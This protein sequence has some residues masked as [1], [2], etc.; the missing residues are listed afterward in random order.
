MRYFIPFLIVLFALAVLLRVDFFF[1]VAYFLFG[2]WVLARLWTRSAVDHLRAGRRFGDHAFTGDTV[3]VE[4]TLRNTGWLPLPWL[5]VGEGLPVQLQTTPFQRRV[6][7]LAP[8][9]EQRFRYDLTCRQRG[10]YAVGPL[11]ARTGDVLGVTQRDLMLVETQHLTVYPRIVPLRRLALPTRS[12][13]AV[14]PARAPLFEDPARLMGVREYQRGDSPR[15][16]HWPATARTSRLVVKQYQP[17]IARETLIC[18]DLF[19]DDYSRQRRYDATEL[20]IVAAASLAN[21]I[22]VAEG[23]PVGLATVALDPLTGSRARFALPPRRER[24]HLIHLLE[25]LARVQFTPGDAD[26][27]D[28]AE[29][30]FVNLVRRQS[31][32]LAWGAT[33]VLITGRAAPDLAHILLHLQRSGFAVTLLLMQPDR[34]PDGAALTGVPGVP[35]REVWSERDL[36]AV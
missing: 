4:L 19:Q 35:V 28:G 18:L 9:E 30:A 1:T 34:G 14:L 26:G 13:L 29:T 12:P 20:A 33:L 6:V 3:E 25:I 23:L 15:R 22:I 5:E 21:H 17:A 10:Y 31:L 7:S 27:A 24:A 11:T 16:I 8:H 2:L 36:E 32:D